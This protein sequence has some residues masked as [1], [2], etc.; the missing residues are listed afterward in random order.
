MTTSANGTRIKTVEVTIEGLAAVLMHRFGAADE[1]QGEARPVKLEDLTPAEQA[2]RSAY[3]L[4]DGS[5][6]MPGAAISRLLREAGSGHKQT[7]TRKSIK[8]IVPAAVIVTDD[9]IVLHDQAGQPITEIE[10]DS[11]PVTIPATKGR[12]MRHRA[13]IEKW[14]ATFSMEID[15][16]VLSANTVHQLLEEGGRRIGIL[17]FRP[18]KGGPYG[19]FAVV[20]WRPI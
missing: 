13:R 12:I 4:E 15:E 14:A 5:L 9:A 20:A 19:R 7:G 17:D 10:V 11:R 18:E 1:L 3:R 8:Y 16:N 6:Y 2:E